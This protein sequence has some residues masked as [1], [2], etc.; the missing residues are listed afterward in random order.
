[1]DKKRYMLDMSEREHDAFLQM[2]A[3]YER[4]SRVG[5]PDCQPEYSPSREALAQ[6]MK[7]IARKVFE[8]EG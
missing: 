1:M 8:K 5:R 3:D 6:R 4:L 7:V 2:V